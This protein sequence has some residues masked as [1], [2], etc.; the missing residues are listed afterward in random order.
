MKYDMQKRD[1]AVKGIFFR[2]V[3]AGY[4]G[5][6]GYSIMTEKETSMSQAAAWMLGGLFMA[7]C[8]GFAVYSVC[9]F[10]SDMAAARLTDAAHDSAVKE[11]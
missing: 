2:L 4:I 1:K 8:A 10:R 11:E 6:L 7:V 5:Y 3:A 9:R